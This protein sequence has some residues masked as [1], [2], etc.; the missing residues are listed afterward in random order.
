MDYVSEVIIGDI[1]L[2]YNVMESKARQTTKKHIAIHMRFH[3]A[4]L[5]ID[6][7]ILSHLRMN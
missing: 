4:D 1:K 3:G 7:N 6:R 2:S 5:S